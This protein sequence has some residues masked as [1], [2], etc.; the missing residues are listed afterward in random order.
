MCGRTDACLPRSDSRTCCFSLSVSLRSGT[1][2]WT[3]VMGSPSISTIT[4]TGVVLTPSGMKA[5][6]IARGVMPAKRFALNSAELAAGRS[7][8]G[9][10]PHA[11]NMNANAALDAIHFVIGKGLSCRVNCRDVVHGQCQTTEVTALER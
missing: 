8:S 9:V 5:G 3:T 4:L 2:D 7:S 1:W 11:P 6:V 10:L